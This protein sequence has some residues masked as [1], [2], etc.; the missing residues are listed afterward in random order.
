MWGVSNKLPGGGGGGGVGGGAEDHFD[1]TPLAEGLFFLFRVYGFLFRVF[2][3][4][5]MVGTNRRVLGF[6]FL[7]C[8]LRP[9]APWWSS[10]N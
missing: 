9:G 3:L 5:L 1:P 4:G 10:R 8:I 2:C 7:S 6:R